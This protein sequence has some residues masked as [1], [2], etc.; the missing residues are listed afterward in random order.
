MNEPE[1]LE[2]TEAAPVE[3]EEFHGDDVDPIRVD[4]LKRLDLTRRF[5]FFD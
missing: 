2:K 4:D 3:W 1:D 5:A